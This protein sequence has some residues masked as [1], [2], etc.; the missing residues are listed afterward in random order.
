MFHPSMNLS[1]YM[2]DLL[3]LRASYTPCYCSNQLLYRPDLVVVSGND[4]ILE[5][6]I[7]GNIP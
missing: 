7:P 1:H 4:P 5:L 2:L 6:T 3:G